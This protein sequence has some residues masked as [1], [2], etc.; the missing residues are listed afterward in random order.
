MEVDCFSRLSIGSNT[1]DSSSCS[2]GRSGLFV[3]VRTLKLASELLC[4]GVRAVPAQFKTINVNCSL[5]SIR[6]RVEG[7]AVCGQIIVRSQ[8][9]AL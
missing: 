1:I 6:H 2:I 9:D 8:V 5:L 3:F 4:L 7:H